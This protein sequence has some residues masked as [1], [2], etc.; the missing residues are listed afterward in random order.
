[1]TDRSSK[2]EAERRD[3]VN[4]MMAAAQEIRAHVPASVT[5]DHSWLYDEDG[6]PAGGGDFSLTDIEPALKD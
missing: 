1:M 2:T 3:R 4:R 5:S 6:L